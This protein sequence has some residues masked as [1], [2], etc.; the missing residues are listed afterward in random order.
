MN[1][2]R[3]QGGAARLVVLALLVSIL[4]Q[5][6]MGFLAGGQGL[7]LPGACRC[8]GF[9]FHGALLACGWPGLAGHDSALGVLKAEHASFA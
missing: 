6:V 3:A 8:A 9:G 7:R 5:N 1:G 4:S 2:T